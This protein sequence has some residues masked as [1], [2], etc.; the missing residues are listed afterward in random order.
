[1]YAQTDELDNFVGNWIGFERMTIEWRHL[2]SIIGM[3]V[4][5]KQ[6]TAGNST[7]NG[8]METFGARAN[9][10]DISGGVDVD[11][12][13][14]TS[15]LLKPNSTPNNIIGLL[16]ANIYTP[17]SK[18]IVQDLQ[19]AN[20]EQVRKKS[21]ELIFGSGEQ[22]EGMM[23]TY[24]FNTVIINGQTFNLRSFDL[25]FDPVVFGL[26]RET[27]QFASTAYFM[28]STKT[29]DAEGMPRRYM[30][31][32]YL[33]NSAGRVDRLMSVVELGR[34]AAIPTNGVD[35]LTIDFLTQAGLDFY[36][37]KQCAYWYDATLS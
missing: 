29:S 24:D 36:A 35:N 23:A 27:N 32:N 2:K 37:M 17:L 30:E 5:G 4:L 16:G 8:M 14:E 3:T 7:S 26:N 9:S 33:S 18:A 15:D 28:P 25:S 20:I 19:N 12:L 1:L 22:S 31:L 34:N 10:L 11:S 13:Y 6:G 21:A